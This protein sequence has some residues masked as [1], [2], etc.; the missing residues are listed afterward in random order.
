VLSGRLDHN[1]V[2]GTAISP[3]FSVLWKPDAHIRL[4]GSI[5]SGFKAPDFR[6]LFVTFSNRL[7]GAGY[8]LIGAQRLG[9][10]LEPER[11]VSYDVG[12]RYED[13]HRQLSSSTSLLYNA[14]VRSFRNDLNNL[15]EFYYVKSINGRDVYSYRNVAQAYTQ[16]IEANLTLARAYWLVF[17]FRG[18]SVP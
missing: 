12:V 9:V 5:G 14:E 10:T 3:R 2:Y 18:L 17:Y 1:S 4:S 6:Q 16:G 13:G 11:S 8:D 7:A 15:I